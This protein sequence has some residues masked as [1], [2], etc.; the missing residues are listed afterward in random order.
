MA[1]VVAVHAVLPLTGACHMPGILNAIPPTWRRRLVGAGVLLLVFGAG[2]AV[3]ARSRSRV[4]AVTDTQTATVSNESAGLDLVKHE[5]KKVAPTV[6][7][8]TI[9]RDGPVRE[10]IVE[11]SGG[12]DTTTDTQKQVKDDLH[13]ETKTT[14]HQSVT[15]AP[16]GRWSFRVLA[17]VDTGGSVVAGAGVEY[18]LLGPATAGAQVLAPV[19]G[20]P[21]R[22]TFLGSLGLRLP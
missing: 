6:K 12:S 9:Y 1:V 20:A 18:R 15:S 10:R 21:G 7:T 2:C 14:E 8:R 13:V 22:F 4:V 19:A 11:R 3:G 17:G 16:E 5:E